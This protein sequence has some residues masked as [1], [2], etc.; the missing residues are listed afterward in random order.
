[1]SFGG[2]VAAMISTLRRNKALS[3]RPSMFKQKKR[4]Q[5]TGRRRFFNERKPSQAEIKEL[6]LKIQHENSV[7]KWKVFLWTVLV[8]IILLG[9]TATFLS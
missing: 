4:Y 3:K 5:G 8:L 6:R 7:R 2:S 9:M 1:M